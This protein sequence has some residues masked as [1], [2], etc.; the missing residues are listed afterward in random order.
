VEWRYSSITVINCK[1]DCLI[2]FIYL[3]LVFF[4]SFSNNALRS[5]GDV[6][7]S[8]L[9]WVSIYPGSSFCGLP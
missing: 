9:G 1:F 8:N 2:Q 4:V 6:R 7:G 3:I 5:I